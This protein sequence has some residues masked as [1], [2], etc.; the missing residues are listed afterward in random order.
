MMEVAGADDG[1]PVFLLHG[2]PGSRSGPRPRASV[3]YRLGVRLISYDRPGYGMSSRQAGRSVADAA[4]DVQTIA[5]DLG[6]DEFAVV[7]RSG[8][9]PHALACAALLPDRVAR[10]AVLVGLAPL[11]ARGLDWFS[12]MTGG[13][14]NDYTAASAD[15][16]LLSDQLRLR[17]ERVADDPETLIDLLEE[18]MTPA[19]KRVVNQIGFRRLLTEA[20]FEA[21]KGGPYGWIDDVVALRTPWGFGFDTIDSQVRLWHG[22]DDNFSPPSHTRWLARQIRRS[23]VSMQ[24]DTAHF[25]A[26]EVLPEI[27][28]WLIA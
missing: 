20:Y 6:L 8:G 7:G 26:M 25:G 2:T 19:D 24:R 14:V 4:F 16:A 5:D 13:N 1:R 27:L 23:E 11:D 9:G 12:G 28:A 17:A 22:A 3:L 10:T 18:Q 21:L 15:S